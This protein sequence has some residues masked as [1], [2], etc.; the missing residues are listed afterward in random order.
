LKSETEQKEKL[1][2]DYSTLLEKL[3]IM[4][5]ALQPKLQ[6]EQVRYFILYK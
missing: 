6:A 2:K 3:S 5:N 4:K 1:S